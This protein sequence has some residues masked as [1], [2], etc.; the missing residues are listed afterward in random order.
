MSPGSLA[1]TAFTLDFDVLVGREGALI[2]TS[3]LRPGSGAFGEPADQKLNQCGNFRRSGSAGWHY[4]IERDRGRGPFAHD[5]LKPARP[6]VAPNYEFRLNGHPQT[7]AKR[8]HQ[9]IG[10]V[11]AQRPSH[12]DVVPFAREAEELPAVARRQVGIAEAGMRCE[13]SGVRGPPTAR[14]IIRC[15]DQQTPHLTET[16]G[17]HA[18]IR[19]GRDAQCQIE[20]AADHS[21][22]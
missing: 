14:E 10:V 1:Q 4:G 16:P 18:R 19:K 22:V 15:A 9:C 17:D 2:Q 21:I 12:C 3:V 20:A 13:V 11:G 6:K 5:R 8:R 7:R